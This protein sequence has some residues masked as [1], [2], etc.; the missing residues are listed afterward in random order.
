MSDFL[1]PHGLQHARLPCPAL[2][3]GVCSNS[4][5]LSQWCHP[6]ISS[7]ISPFSSCPQ[8]FPAL[9]SFPNELA[10]CIRWPYSGTSPSVLPKNIKSWFPLGLPGLISLQSKGFSRVFSS[11]ITIYKHT[12]MSTFIRRRQWHPTPV[13]L[14][15]KSHGQRS[16][17]GCSPWGC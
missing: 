15:G 7:C 1:Q 6:T 16:P 12:H 14:P 17:V 13:L 3:L 2:A 5:L 8:S 4:R 11:T 10:L 9:G